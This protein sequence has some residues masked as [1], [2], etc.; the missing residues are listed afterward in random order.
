MYHRNSH[1]HLHQPQ[2]KNA[3]FLLSANQNSKNQIFS[4]PK[5][6]KIDEK[7]AQNGTLQK[8]T[9]RGG[10]G[11]PSCSIDKTPDPELLGSEDKSSTLNPLSSLVLRSWKNDGEFESFIGVERGGKREV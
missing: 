8:E 1:T 10:L 5:L 2:L 9:A 6:E 11:F 7:S 3:N 4:Q